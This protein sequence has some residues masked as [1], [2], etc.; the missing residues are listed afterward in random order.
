MPVRNSHWY[1]HNEGRSYPLDERASGLSDDGVRLPANVLVDLNLRWPDALGRYAFVTA[2]SVTNSSVTLTI[3]AAADLDDTTSFAPLA[4]ITARKPIAEGRSYALLPQAAGVAGW[5]VFGSGAVDLNYRGRFSTPAQSALAMRAARAYRPL[6]VAGIEAQHA[7]RALTGVVTLKAL[8]PLRLTKEERFVGGA[9]RDC[10]V[11]GLSDTEGTDGF[12]RADGAESGVARKSVFE[13]FA[14]PCAGRPESTTCGCP[15]PIQFINAVAPDC[16]GVLTIEF[17]GCA[18]VAQIT[19]A[20]GVALACQ[21]GLIDACLAGR[22]PSSAGLLP[23][24]YAPAAV[25]LSPP[26]PPAP[27]PGGVSDSR[28]PLPAPLAACFV[29]GTAELTVVAGGWEFD[30][31]DDT[32]A[33]C[34]AVPASQSAS[35]SDASYESTSAGGRNVAVFEVDTTTIYRTATTEAKLTAGP[36]GAKRNAQ[37]IVNYRAHATAPGRYVYY[38]AE[39]DYDTQQFKI[40][41]FNGTAFT[42]VAAGDAVGLQLNKWYAVS[43]SVRPSGDSGAVSL[44]ARVLSITNPGA[45]DVTVQAVVGDYQP[46]TGKFGVGTNRAISR[47]AYLTVEEDS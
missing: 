43:V 21:F 9:N 19:N 34:P 31:D 23:S 24:E 15:E 11:V 29:A 35:V 42:T 20:S 14:G 28:V 3:Q 33:L 22:L 13:Q 39:V 47:F 5:V 32:A 30:T 44:S 37:L 26:P 4:V 40:V 16:D 1:S 17:A 38:A 41:R 36:A 46:S 12:G 2:V 10:I 27:D 6:P 45:T 7:A 18:Q 8:P 25:R